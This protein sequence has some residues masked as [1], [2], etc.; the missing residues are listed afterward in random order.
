ML[1]SLNTTRL[2]KVGVGSGQGVG[3]A[4][5]LTVPAFLRLGEL[6][7][8]AGAHPGIVQGLPSSQHVSPLAASESKP[9]RC[10]HERSGENWLSQLK[11]ITQH[12]GW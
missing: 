6:G 9:Q 4:S 3:E 12:D 11:E 2:T 5:Y 7:R 10:T 1:T 8:A